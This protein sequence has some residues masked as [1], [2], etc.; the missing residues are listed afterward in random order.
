MKDTM[1]LY[2]VKEVA[3]ILHTTPAT[4]N[5]LIRNNTLSAVKLGT[6]KVKSESLNSF[7]AANAMNYLLSVSGGDC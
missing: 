3:E 2:T 5:L 4:V 1:K 7:I 6:F